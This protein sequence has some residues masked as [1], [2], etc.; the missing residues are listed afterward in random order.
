MKF[1]KRDL[2]D[3]K[4]VEKTLRTGFD[5]DLKGAAYCIAV[6]GAIVLTVGVTITFTVALAL[7]VVVLRAFWK[8]LGGLNG[9]AK[10]ANMKKLN[11]KLN[12]L[13]KKC[14]KELK[15]NPNDKDAKK[16]L[17]AVEAN[18]KKIETSSKSVSESFMTE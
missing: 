10:K 15:K 12:Q 6:L 3:P 4:I 18:L 16:M 7:S 1:T 13:K 14:E 2:T 8:F 11:T 17:T 5:S 9:M